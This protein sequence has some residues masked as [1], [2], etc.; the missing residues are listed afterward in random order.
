MFRQYLWQQFIPPRFI[1]KAA[2][3][4]FFLCHL[5]D[6]KTIHMKLP[7]ISSSVGPLIKAPGTENVV[8]YIQ[9]T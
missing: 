3:I 7:K 6:M 5:L 9:W 1:T 2:M 8:F 4:F